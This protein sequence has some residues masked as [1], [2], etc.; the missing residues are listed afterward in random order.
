MK[1]IQSLCL[2]LI[3]SFLISS[4]GNIT[5]NQTANSS[6]PNTNQTTEES[7][8]NEVEVVELSEVAM[9]LVVTTGDNIIYTSP[10]EGALT[11]IPSEFMQSMGEDVATEWMI[12]TN[13]KSDENP[14]VLSTSNLYS[15]IKAFD[16][17]EDLVRDYFVKQREYINENDWLSDEDID[18]LLSDDTAK[19]A[20]RFANTYGYFSGDE[21]YS[22]KWIYEH[23][24][25]DYLAH[26]LPLDI[27]VQKLDVI[28]KADN[29]LNS[30]DS[31]HAI[32]LK[33]EVLK[34]VQILV[35]NNTQF[36]ITPN[37]NEQTLDVAAPLENNAQSEK[38]LGV[39]KGEVKYS[40]TWL[41]ENDLSAY[42]N[43]GITAEDL[44]LFLDDI[45]IYSDSYE[46]EILQSSYNKMIANGG[47]TQAIDD[48]FG[49]Y[50]YNID[51]V[52]Y[53]VEWLSRNTA[54]EWL[55]VGID[56]EVAGQILEDISAFSSTDEYKIIEEIYNSLVD[57]SNIA[58][59]EHYSHL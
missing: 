49:N 52:E 33:I 18:L 11:L 42:E 43:A 24:V 41:A 19:V 32:S 56:K 30:I 37:M 17:S 8:Q 5:D 13:A 44:K 34:Q 57:V 36:E 55:A 48:G 50:V 47:N 3:L 38:V 9:P 39:V 35:G 16:V 10:F 40:T 20:E 31:K 51:G 21:V 2:V 23:S 1:K 22:P 6:K 15:F 53:N 46:Y 25:A 14:T 28:A 58:D 45:S 59:T 54:Q 29:M 12:E 7:A 27:I 26:E 4:C